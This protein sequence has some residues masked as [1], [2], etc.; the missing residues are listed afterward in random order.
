MAWDEAES[1]LPGTTQDHLKIFN[2]GTLEWATEQQAQLPGTTQDHLKIFN[3][4]TLEW[5]TE[6]EKKG[7]E[8]TKV[9]AD[10][11]AAERTRPEGVIDIIMGAVSNV[12]DVVKD[13]AVCDYSIPFLSWTD[14]WKLS[15]GPSFCDIFDDTISSE[16][17]NSRVSPKNA[18]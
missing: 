17:K 6:D 14:K 9:N 2:K 5:A 18:D 16:G 13:K 15:T 1:Q 4:G 8:K 7:C 10:T 3:K 11:A 12:A